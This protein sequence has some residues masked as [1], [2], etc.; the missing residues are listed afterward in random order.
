MPRITLASI[1]MITILTVLLAF[2]LQSYSS[3]ADKHQGLR[4]FA[5]MMQVLAHPRCMNCHQDRRPRIRD[6]RRVH[7][8]RLNAGNNGFGVGGHRCSICH[9]DDN[10]TLT[11]IPGVPGWRMPPYSMSW[12]GLEPG[13]ICS[14]IKDKNMNG[15]RDLA[16]V[17]HHLEHDLLVVWAWAP[18]KARQPAPF[19]HQEFIARTKDWISHGAPCPEIESN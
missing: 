9:R 12:N 4:A 10:T 17:L 7:I 5:D 14:N 2:F 11:R 6:G 1:V 8:P 13:D 18:G 3:A 19:S 16:D 15:G